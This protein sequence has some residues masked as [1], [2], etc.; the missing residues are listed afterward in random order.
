M[1]ISNK[2]TSIVYS[3]HNSINKKEENIEELI[4]SYNFRYKIN[5][6]EKIDSFEL[7]FLNL[8]SYYHNIVI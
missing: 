2:E 1:P 6:I 5:K 4:K 8:R 3:I 7:K